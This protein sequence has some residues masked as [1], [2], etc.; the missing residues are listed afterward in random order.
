MMSSYSPNKVTVIGHTHPDTDSIC[1]AIAYAWLKNHTDAPIYEA[2]SAGSIN[3]ETAFALEYSGV[4]KPKICRICVG[5]AGRGFL[6]GV[7][8]KDV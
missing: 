7:C 1:S 8:R 6:G 4:P 5:G 2:K 3:R